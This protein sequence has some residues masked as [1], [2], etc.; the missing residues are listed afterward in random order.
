[1]PSHTPHRR[2]CYECHHCSC[3][4]FHCFPSGNSA[5]AATTNTCPNDIDFYFR[6][7]D[8]PDRVQ[9]GAKLAKRSSSSSG[10]EFG[11]MAVKP[12]AISAPLDDVEN[13][14]RQQRR[15]SSDA[16]APLAKLSDEE[17]QLSIQSCCSTCTSGRT[18]RSSSD[19]G[20]TSDASPSNPA[21]GSR[22]QKS[23]TTNFHIRMGG[24]RQIVSIHE[25][26]PGRR[27]DQRKKRGEIEA[28]AAPKSA[29]INQK[30]QKRA[31]ELDQKTMPERA[32]Q[33]VEKY[34]KMPMRMVRFG[35]GCTESSSTSLP[36]SPTTILKRH[37]RQLKRLP[38]L[39]KPSPEAPNAVVRDANACWARERAEWLRMRQEAQQRAVQRAMAT[40]RG[41][42]AEEVVSHRRKE[43]AQDLRVT[44]HRMLNDDGVEELDR[45]G[46]GTHLKPEGILDEQKRQA[47][48][49][50]DQMRQT[51]AELS[52]SSEGGTPMRRPI[53][54]KV[55]KSNSASDLASAQ[56]FGP[57]ALEEMECLRQLMR[58]EMP[59]AKTGKKHFFGRLPFGK[60]RRGLK[61][62]FNGGANT[63]GLEM[64]GDG[65]TRQ[66]T[67]Q[68]M[69]LQRP[70]G[71]LHKILR[72]GGVTMDLNQQQQQQPTA[73]GANPR[74]PQQPQYHRIGQPQPPPPSSAAVSAPRVR[75][76]VD[77]VDGDGYAE[78][79]HS[80][81]WK[82]RETSAPSTS[83]RN[84]KFFEDQQQQLY[85]QLGLVQ[86]PSAA[87]ATGALPCHRS[88]S[89]GQQRTSPG[90]I[91]HA[92][93]QQSML[94]QPMSQ[95]MYVQS[96][97]PQQHAQYGRVGNGAFA[98]Y[99]PPV[100]QQHRSLQQQFAAARSVAG[101]QQHEPVGGGG[102]HFPSSA[103]GGGGGGGSISTPPA[104]KYYRSRQ[105]S[106]DEAAAG[107]ALDEATRDMLRLSAEPAGKFA[108]LDGGGRVAAVQ[109]A[110]STSAVQRNL[111]SAQSPVDGGRFRM[112]QL[113]DTAEPQ[114]VAASAAVGGV[115]ESRDYSPDTLSASAAAAVRGRRSTA[116]FAGLTRS[117]GP[118]LAQLTPPEQQ[119]GGAGDVGDPFAAGDGEEEELGGSSRVLIHHHACREHE[120][121][122]RQKKVGTPMV[123]TTVEGK[124]KMEKSVGS[125][126][127]RCDHEV[128]KAYTLRDT[129]THYRI[130]TTFG[131]RQ[132]LVEE[133]QRAASGMSGEEEGAPMVRSSGTYRLSVYEDG[134]EVGMHEANIQLPEG[135][136]KPDYLAKV[137]E[138]LLAD[139]ASLDDSADQ[140]TA[141]TRVE[142]ERV[143]DVT[144]IVKTYRI[145]EA[146]P[147]E[148][149]PAEVPIP[150]L[151][152]PPME[153]F[154]YESA[155]DHLS[156]H[157]GPL[158]ME[159]RIYIDQLEQDE[160]EEL[161]PRDI[162]LLR[163]GVLIEGE[164]RIGPKRKMAEE[165]SDEAES[166]EIRREREVIAQ[167]DCDLHRNEDRSLMEVYIAVPLLQQLTVIM[168]I[169][170]ARPRRRTREL[171]SGYGMERRGQYFQDTAHLAR[172]SRYES[173]E[174]LAE[175]AVSAVAPQLIAPRITVE[176]T[177]YTEEEQQ[178][179]QQQQSAF[180][181]EAA[182]LPPMP[183][184][185]ERVEVL[186]EKGGETHFREAGAGAATYQYELAGE[187]Y[188]GRGTL[189][190]AERRLQ[191][192]EE[193]TEEGMERASMEEMHAA[194]SYRMEQS[195]QLLE[196]DA[197][198]RRTRR[199]ES[200]TSVDYEERAGGGITHVTMV[201]KEASGRFEL[202]VELANEFTPSLAPLHAREQLQQRY[203]TLEYMRT[204]EREQ[205]ARADSHAV[206][207][208]ASV[209]SARFHTSAQQFADTW[210]NVHMERARHLQE[211]YSESGATQCWRHRRQEA[212]SF[213]L[214]ESS[215]EQAV[216][217]YAFERDARGSD[218]ALA[219]RMQREVPSARPAPFFATEFR[220]EVSQLNLSIGAPARQESLLQA[221]GKARDV[222]I[223]RLQKSYSEALHEG[224]STVFFLRNAAPTE[225]PAVVRTLH[226]L[227]ESKGHRLHTVAQQLVQLTQHVHVARKEYDM[228]QLSTETVPM[229][230]VRRDAVR[231]QLREFLSESEWCSV[232][233]ENRAALGERVQM[234]WRDSVHGG[235]H[236]LRRPALRMHQHAAVLSAWGHTG[237]IRKAH[238]GS[239]VTTTTTTTCLPVTIHH[240]L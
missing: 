57:E 86:P 143:E 206:V 19:G 239:T 238:N 13:R 94:H 217:M 182:E 142:I 104:R 44:L 4:C 235:H 240:I 195:G 22:R 237:T 2:H 219:E 73:G 30:L 100:Q 207:Q 227:R 45:N 157:L 167:V 124:L 97:T 179:Q 35:N 102:R 20:L 118:P 216:L 150:T 155:S 177:T 170:R 181:Y 82:R 236:L 14:R 98:V 176:R 10:F 96:T 33:I 166:V 145:G 101:G 148:E 128:A 52:S 76:F 23:N 194:A 199:Y 151:L 191:R 196:G 5:A 8:P 103:V 11:G 213:A 112:A 6:R 175:S 84:V 81:Q 70:A 198:V 63:N 109:K 164:T 7:A 127:L 77:S 224:A 192:R 120:L 90:T 26:L 225:A 17:L 173:E 83:P 221:E 210:L 156:D 16:R 47:A 105:P 87:A 115:T 114:A 108:R 144:D 21:A 141:V 184:S 59:G 126:L 208:C 93:Q 135:I 220:S 231:K 185:R 38:N 24:Q 178:Q 163:E 3:C 133:L 188:D 111:I 28:V 189:R 29:V 232:L 85:A 117:T 18:S 174:S 37:S 183:L 50:V 34:A 140:M 62:M 229:R 138:K 55:P 113:Q 68:E 214:Q 137:S 58:G 203:E 92:A 139:L 146:A 205:L 31:D 134:K 223:E 65:S 226:E 110:A 211:R 190:V 107:A 131:K 230:E 60:M 1:M 204:L 42:W 152:A 36:S 51:L 79:G 186:R 129:V 159:S 95:S 116:P 200:E 54:L 56:N 122:G 222:R 215:A 67:P 40:A 165:M 171:A 130:R 106:V 187:L 75:D 147:K 169:H 125:H 153:E 168:R 202:T 197:K 27:I 88:G 39:A 69:P 72:G 9:I 136:S 15:H 201:K 91:L 61:Q 158:E 119:I 209:W 80:A 233:M 149:E 234:D 66:P 162:R 193:E 25:M 49:I 132:L 32:P 172:K 53:I 121:E 89:E 74:H 78:I 46:F 43:M 161:E 64:D 12:K 212:H 154:T 48:T 228:A 71:F 99:T 123:K 218:R 160:L 180:R 41:R